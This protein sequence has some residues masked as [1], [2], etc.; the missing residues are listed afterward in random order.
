MKYLFPGPYAPAH[1]ENKMSS[2]GSV[3]DAREGFL[4]S[5]FPNV[6]ALLRF[7]Y[8]WMNEYLRSNTVIVEVGSGAGC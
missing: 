3:S 4:K 6:D 7:R 1:N 2:E 8:D 5:R